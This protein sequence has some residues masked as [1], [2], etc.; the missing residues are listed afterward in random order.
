MKRAIIAALAAVTL[1]ATAGIA[2]GQPVFVAHRG[3]IVPGYPENTLAAYRHSISQGVPVIEIDLRG[4]QDGHIV[5]MHDP[6]LD[7]T[8]DGHGPVEDHTL[9]QLKTLDAGNGERIPTYEE[10]LREIDTT[11]PLLLLDIKESKT[12]DLAKVVRITEQHN[13]TL[14]VIVGAR[15][16]DD[17]RSF[18]A[19]NRNLR[20][21]G[22]IQSPEDIDAYVEAGAGIIRL[23]PEWIQADPS[24]IAKV[25]ARGHPVWVTAGQAN[26]ETLE[27]LVQMGVDGILSDFPELTAQLSRE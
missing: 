8:T 26:K 19:L 18:K 22:F 21:L 1:A 10:V 5:I 24:L 13:A 23:W 12:L 14:K 6:T 25:Q 11:G 9:A 2:G 27:A 16:L 20:V 17:L 4:T 7:R 15:S 3:G